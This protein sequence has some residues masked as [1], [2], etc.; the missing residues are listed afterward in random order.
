M[1]KDCR[2]LNRNQESKDWR[3]LLEKETHEAF[4][5]DHYREMQLETLEKSDKDAND[6][7][8]K[9]MILRLRPKLL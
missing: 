7:C 4:D 1:Q 6:A 2:D 5:D 3:W 8:E 9:K